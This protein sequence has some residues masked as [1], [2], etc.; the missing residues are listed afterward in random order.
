VTNAVHICGPG[1]N[2]SYNY[3]QC[4]AFG[5]Y[6][7]V[8]D[9]AIV[10]VENASGPPMTSIE[11]DQ[12]DATI[13]GCRPAGCAIPISSGM[14]FLGRPYGGNTGQFSRFATSPSNTPQYGTGST[15]VANW[16]FG[17]SPG[18]PGTPC[19]TPGALYSFTGATGTADSVEVC[20]FISTG[21]FQWASIP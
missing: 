3:G 18:V 14:Y 10:G 15:V 5:T 17:P 1:S 19:Y 7:S 8:T 20:T 2:S 9:V 6:G 4:D 11:D 21:G 13:S 12:T 16:G